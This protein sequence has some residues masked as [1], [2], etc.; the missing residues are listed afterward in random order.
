MRDFLFRERFSYF[1]FVCIIACTYIL[2]RVSEALGIWGIL[3]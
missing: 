3:G 1:D 2:Q